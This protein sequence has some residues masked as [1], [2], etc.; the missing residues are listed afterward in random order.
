MGRT[1]NALAGGDCT[2]GLRGSIDR[3]AAAT[4]ALAVNFQEAR[5][6]L[7]R[8]KL[9]VTIFANGLITIADDVGVTKRAAATAMRAAR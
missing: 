6:V 2:L 9:A 8:C 1:M 4:R 3:F 7:P 5:H